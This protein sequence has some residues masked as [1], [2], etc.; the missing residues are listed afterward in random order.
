MRRSLL[1]SVFLVLVVLPL[2]A[3][4]PTTR[5]NRAAPATGH[6]EQVAATFSI[7]A[8]DPAKQEWG[9]AVESKYFC[10]ACAV[11][12]A[13]AGVGGVATQAFVNISFGPKALALLKAGFTAEQALKTLID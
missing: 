5:F 11:P 9:V 10:V 2:W 3:Q 4:A 6:E 8:Y 7:V 12:W 1:I 13:E